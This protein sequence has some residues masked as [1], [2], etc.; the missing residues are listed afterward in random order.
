MQTSLET[1]TDDSGDACRL[2]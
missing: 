2:G 1:K